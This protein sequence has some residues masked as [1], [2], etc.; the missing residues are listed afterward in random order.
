MEITEFHCTKGNEKK[1]KKHTSKTAD[2]QHLPTP[3]EEKSSMQ[4]GT[5]LQPNARFLERDKQ[6][7]KSR[8]NQKRK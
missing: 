2:M 6:Q 8:N 1:K 4:Y 3:S 7:V 5:F